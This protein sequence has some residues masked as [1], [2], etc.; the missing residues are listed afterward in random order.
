MVIDWRS[1]I[2]EMLSS[3]EYQNIAE[4]YKPSI[5]DKLRVSRLE[6][7]H[8]DFWRWLLD[9]SEG[10][11]LG[12]APAECF[13]RVL[14]LADENKLSKALEDE[15]ADSFKNQI[16]LGNRVAFESNVSREKCIKYKGKDSRIDLLI[17]MKIKEMKKELVICVEN[18]VKSNENN[19]Q[20][21]AY[22]EAVNE[23]YADCNRIY[24]YL[25]PKPI[26]SLTEMA[27]CRCKEFIQ[28]DYQLLMDNI[29]EPMKIK[30][31]SEEDKIFIEN[32]M[33]CLSRPVVDE[34]YNN[35][36]K[37]N[38]G[39]DIIMCTSESEKELL[40]SFYF[41]H[42]ELVIAVLDS[43]KDDDKNDTIGKCV[44][45]LKKKSPK[46]Y[47]KYSF[48]GKEYNKTRL[49]LAVAHKIAND[50]GNITLEEMKEI[51]RQDKVA[52][53]TEAEEKNKKDKYKRW[54]TKDDEKIE[55]SD[56]TEIAISNQ[57]TKELIDEFISKKKVNNIKYEIKEI[58]DKYNS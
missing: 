49:M 15:D 18:K 46:D 14:L 5:F 56:G 19:E 22:F 52:L 57:W 25:T 8:S 53:L 48:E 30:I 31:K 23:K 20:T 2:I 24:V 29:L 13:L 4:F 42:K 28:I 26:S 39:G 55:L 50:K 47:T 41:R 11:S 27:E 17:K 43:L 21:E 32:Y 9:S 3:K 36:G 34:L 6:S 44:N 7:V 33:R 58:K 37:K 16:I 35:E 10:H 1:R 38:K 54:L 45:Y 12:V 51:F 40:R